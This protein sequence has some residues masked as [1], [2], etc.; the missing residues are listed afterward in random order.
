MWLIMVV[1][2]RAGSVFFGGVE[3]WCLESGECRVVLVKL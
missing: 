3:V 2:V 1:D